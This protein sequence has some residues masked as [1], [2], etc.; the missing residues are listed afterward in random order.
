MHTSKPRSSD[1]IVRHRINKWYSLRERTARRRSMMSTAGS[2]MIVLLAPLA[3]LLLAFAIA[4]RFVVTRESTPFVMLGFEQVPL[5]YLALYGSVMSCLSFW[6]C[7]RKSAQRHQHVRP[8]T[9]SP[10]VPRTAVQALSRCAAAASSRAP[11]RPSRQAAARPCC[12]RAVQS[13]SRS[14]CPV[15]GVWLIL[16]MLL[17]TS[18]LFVPLSSA[19]SLRPPAEPPPAS[20]GFPKLLNPS[21]CGL[22]GSGAAFAHADLVASRV[23]SVSIAELDV[24]LGLHAGSADQW[25]QKDAPSSRAASDRGVW[26]PSLVASSRHR[27][28]SWR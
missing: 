22:D 8:A 11:T 21:T 6:L 5:L 28:P 25:S 3:H 7:L 4:M 1:P 9:S 26:P 16:A 27:R 18:M 24:S 17:A 23:A 2:G 13:C 10:R 12:T 20:A 14:R 15:K 19:W